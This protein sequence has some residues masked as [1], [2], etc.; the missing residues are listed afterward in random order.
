MIGPDDKCRRCEAPLIL[1]RVEHKS[2][3]VALDAEPEE[4]FVGGRF[5]VVKGTRE[6]VRVVAGQTYDDHTAH[7]RHRCTR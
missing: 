1:C 7:S 5:A 2:K 4:F 6:C 3:T